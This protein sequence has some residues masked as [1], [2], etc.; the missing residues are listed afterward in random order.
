M[1]DKIAHIV[2]LVGFGWTASHV[3]G[4]GFIGTFLRC[5]YLG[6]AGLFAVLV[7]SDWLAVLK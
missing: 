4:P 7:A 6:G 1:I 3:N 5:A 2:G